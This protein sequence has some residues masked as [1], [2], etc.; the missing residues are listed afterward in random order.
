MFSWLVKIY[1]SVREVE[2]K[3]R[4]TH[5]ALQFSMCD[6][7]WRTLRSSHNFTVPF[8]SRGEISTWANKSAGRACFN[9]YRWLIYFFDHLK[10]IYIGLLAPD[11]LFTVIQIKQLRA[12]CTILS[13]VNARL[14]RRMQKLQDRAQPTIGKHPTP[15]TKQ[16]ISGYIIT[17]FLKK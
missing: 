6:Y 7:S 5:R 9:A 13:G 1:T 16:I 3:S 4:R 14:R 17:E 11:I 10:K 12:S 8:Y 15:D 2:N